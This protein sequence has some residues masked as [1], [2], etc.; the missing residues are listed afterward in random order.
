MYGEIDCTLERTMKKLKEWPNNKKIVAVDFDGTIT[1]KDNR[2][3]VGKNK[4]INDIK[5]PNKDVINSILQYRDKIYLI[6]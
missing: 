1:L 5:E 3:W 6:L 2:K 4:Y